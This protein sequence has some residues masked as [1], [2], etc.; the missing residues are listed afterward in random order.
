MNAT[1]TIIIISRI[2]GSDAS[3]LNDVEPPPSH[4]EYSD[5][6]DERHAKRQQKMNKQ[7]E[8]AEAEVK[9]PRPQQQQ[10]NHRPADGSSRFGSGKTL[11]ITT[12]CLTKRQ[13][14]SPLFSGVGIVRNRDI[15]LAG[16]VFLSG[17]SIFLAPVRLLVQATTVVEHE[18]AGEQQLE[19][20]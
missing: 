19:A 2:K 11:L 8:A 17:I 1:I 9:E 7:G 18:H 6:E 14:P 10:R 12:I 16:L 20:G 4:I 13:L 3:W 15:S 5:D